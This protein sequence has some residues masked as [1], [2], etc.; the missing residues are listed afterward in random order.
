MGGV[1]S[2]RHW[3]E[4][5]GYDY[6]RDRAAEFAVVSAEQT[7]L[8]AEKTVELPSRSDDW[9]AELWDIETKWKHEELDLADVAEV[10]PKALES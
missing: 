3:V 5:K 10:N 2:C 7:L 4:D 8:G 6:C 9:V 1:H